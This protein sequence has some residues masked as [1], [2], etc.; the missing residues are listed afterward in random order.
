MLKKNFYQPFINIKDKFKWEKLNEYAASL[1]YYKIK[2]IKKV[3]FKKYSKKNKNNILILLLAYYL[4]NDFKKFDLLNNR[5]N[6]LEQIPLNK[7]KAGLTKTEIKNKDQN[8]QIALNDY[9]ELYI[10]IGKDKKVFPKDIVHFIINSMNIKKFQIKNI[11]IFDKYSFFQVP[12]EYS[13][14]AIVLL[15]VKKFRGKKIIVNYSK[16]Q[17]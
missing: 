1:D 15:S 5:I 2:K 7:E 10:N 13:E 12:K 6:W 9:I 16:K 17:L 14:K 3:I 11:K 4:E 8:D